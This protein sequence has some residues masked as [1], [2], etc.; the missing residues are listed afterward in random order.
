M[1]NRGYYTFAVWSGQLYSFDIKAE[2]D[3]L[4]GCKYITH[5]RMWGFSQ[6]LWIMPLGIRLLIRSDQSAI[7]P[8]SSWKTCLCHW[9]TGTEP[10]E[11]VHRAPISLISSAMASRCLS[12]TSA[13]FP[14]Y[15]CS[16]FH[17]RSHVHCL[18]WSLPQPQAVSW[19]LFWRWAN[20]AQ[21]WELV[22]GL[23]LVRGR[24]RTG[25]CASH[26]HRTLAG[27]IFGGSVL[28]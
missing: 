17:M 12:F 9:C 21:R 18:I 19:S 28:C 27:Q 14:C 4:C 15:S 2:R 10:C 24:A 1:L 3:A 22:P 7:P 11:Q 16:E 5:R 26:P 8:C 13:S 25:C 20:E 6:L 23:Q